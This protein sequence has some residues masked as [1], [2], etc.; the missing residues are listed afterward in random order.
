ML[1]QNLHGEIDNYFSFY[2]IDNERS[3]IQSITSI[4]DYIVH[5]MMLLLISD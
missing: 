4:A 3:K 5:P 2:I 1:P